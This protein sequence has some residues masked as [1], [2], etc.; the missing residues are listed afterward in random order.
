MI[1]NRMHPVR[2]NRYHLFATMPSNF[3]AKHELTFAYKSSLL[4]TLIPFIPLIPLIPLI[5]FIP[6]IPLIPLIPFI[7]FIP[8]IPFIGNSK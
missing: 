6:F 7:P 8:L 4:I 1:P 2:A 5:P 3:K